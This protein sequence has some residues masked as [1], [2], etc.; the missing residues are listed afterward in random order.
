MAA[1]TGLNMELT[2]EQKH[3][4]AKPKQRIASSKLRELLVTQA[5]KCALS[6]VDL[7]FDRLERTPVAG[8]AGCHPLSPAVDHV[9]PGCLTSGVQ[10]TCYDLNDLK[11]H[12]PLDCF[13]AL[14][15]TRAWE[16]LMERWRN[17]AKIDP[18]DRDAFRRLLRPTAK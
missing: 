16:D 13:E 7:V 12:L 9:S 14:R 11:G 15:K 10:I 4:A 3:W 1:R 17:Q 8:G 18:S 5:G 6:G 2:S